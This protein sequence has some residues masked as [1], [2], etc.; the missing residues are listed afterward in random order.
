MLIT[1]ICL[2]H[3]LI[4]F[5]NPD[6]RIKQYFGR[7]AFALLFIFTDNIIG[8]LASDLSIAKIMEHY[9]FLKRLY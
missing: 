8:F 5:P 6:G 2:K 9:M 7:L 1:D 4:I 3:F